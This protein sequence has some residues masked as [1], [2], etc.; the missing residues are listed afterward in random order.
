MKIYM[1]IFLGS[2]LGG[3]CRYI[4]SIFISHSTQFQFPIGTL[5]INLTGCFLMGLLAPILMHKNQLYHDQL[6]YLI[7]VGFLGGYTTFSTFSIDTLRLFNEKQIMTALL[8][9]ILSIFGCML[10][11]WI[12]S[13]GGI[14]IN[15]FFKS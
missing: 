13:I 11:V 14:F 3:V 5:L 6:I 4:L 9:M 1:Y 12:G 2:G 10:S 7:L 15:K 8:N